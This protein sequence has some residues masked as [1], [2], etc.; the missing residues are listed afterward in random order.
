MMIQS[1]SMKLYYL[2]RC[3]SHLCLLVSWKQLGTL[4]NEWKLFR[5]KQ[6]LSKGQPIVELRKQKPALYHFN[7]PS[8]EKSKCQE[9]KH[10]MFAYYGFVWYSFLSK[11]YLNRTFINVGKLMGEAYMQLK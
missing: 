6:V 9:S 2:P 11:V 3:H 8:L 7:E 10:S 1:I 5:F 4:N